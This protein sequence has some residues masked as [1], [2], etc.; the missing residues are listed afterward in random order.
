M[1]KE[2]RIA[3]ENRKQ[4]ILDY[5][6]KRKLED[7]DIHASDCATHNEPALPNGICDCF[8]RTFW[9]DDIRVEM[10]DKSEFYPDEKNVY[11]FGYYDGFQRA[12]KYIKS[13]I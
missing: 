10:V 3:I 6:E 5:F 1:K 12:L 7:I 4:E 11:Q 2:T 13:L 9:P 8:D